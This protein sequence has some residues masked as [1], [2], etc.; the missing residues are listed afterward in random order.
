MIEALVDLARRQ[1]R[2]APAFEAASELPLLQH[3]YGL[4]PPGWNVVEEDGRIV[5][6]SGAWARD[7]LWW[8]GDLFV[9]P[10]HHGRGLGR[11]LLRRAL[12]AG[13]EAPNAF[14]MASADLP[15]ISLYLGEGLLPR[16]TALAFFVPTHP[17]SEADPN[18]GLAPLRASKL[19]FERARFGY[20]RGH[21][22]RFLIE[23]GA[24]GF[25]ILGERG[26]R[27]GFLYLQDSGVIGPAAFET[28][29]VIAPALELV[30]AVARD[31]GIESVTLRPPT[32]NIEAVRWCVARGGRLLGQNLLMARAPLDT[33]HALALFAQPGLA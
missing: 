26:E 18:L 25:E 27:G 9:R 29:E 8:L 11:S 1:H 32:S 21:D 2:P 13:T 23:S 10:S 5:A 7:G 28:D 14:T 31:A 19:A 6:F 15:A 24:K 4:S 12:A 33:D 22:H 3:G 16:A 20:A 30:L 17:L